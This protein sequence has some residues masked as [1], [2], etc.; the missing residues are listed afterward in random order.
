MGVVGGTVSMAG[1]PGTA[2]AWGQV[3]QDSYGIDSAINIGTAFATFGMVIG[4][5]LGGPLAARLISRH[6]LESQADIDSVPAMGMGAGERQAEINY[7]SMLRTILVIF[8]A[9][10]M[11]IAFDKLLTSINFL[12][13]EFAACMI[14]GML[15]INV[16]PKLLPKLSSSALEQTI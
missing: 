11:G 10:G 4:G 9:V 5:L 16:G 14:T 6:Q 8:I 2:A 7:D 3:L 15:L 12:L 1:G 13:P